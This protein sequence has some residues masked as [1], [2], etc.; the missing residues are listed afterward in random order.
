M[1]RPAYRHGGD[2]RRR[3]GA[4][5]DD[6]AE[7]GSMLCGVKRSQPVH[8]QARAWR[9]L[10]YGMASIMAISFLSINNVGENPR[11]M[12]AEIASK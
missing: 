7:K 9:S 6:D 1:T 12:A 10:T 4:L 8:A 5:L 3:A 2:R 11:G